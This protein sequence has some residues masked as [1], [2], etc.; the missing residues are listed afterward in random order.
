MLKDSL[1][2]E[3]DLFLLKPLV[4]SKRQAIIMYHLTEALA[5]QKAGKDARKNLMEG[6][7]HG[8][9]QAWLGVTGE[10]GSRRPIGM[11]FTTITMKIG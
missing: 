11:I 6:L 2:Q 5:D 7:V 10:E 9:I 4:I 1:V 8:D 3:V